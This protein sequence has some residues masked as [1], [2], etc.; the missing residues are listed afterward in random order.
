MASTKQEPQKPRYFVTRHPSGA[1]YII[2]GCTA[3]RVYGTFRGTDAQTRC[4]KLNTA[5]QTSEIAAPSAAA[6]P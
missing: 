4:D 2:D 6:T 1:C 5:Q 3:T